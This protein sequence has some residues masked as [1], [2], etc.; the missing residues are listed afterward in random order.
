MKRSTLVVTLILG[1]L[2]FACS[3][4]G[5]TAI[6]TLTQPAA[7]G[8][9]TQIP[10][11]VQDQESANDVADQLQADSI[12]RNATLFKLL[13]KAQG[14]DSKLRS[15]TYDLSP[16][17]SMNSIM[18]VLIAGQPDPGIQIVVGPGLRVLEY[19][20]LFTDLKNF[21]KDD[22]IKIAQTGVYP[23]G[24]KVSDSYWFVPPLHK[25][26]LYTLEGY[27][28]PDTYTFNTTDKAQN[29]INRL[30]N[31]F[32]EHLCPGPDNDPESSN[33]YFHDKASCLKHAELTGDKGSPD[34]FTV[35]KQ[36]Y[37]QTDEVEAL[38]K[39]L[40][41]SSI[42]IRESSSKNSHEDAP[43][44]ADILYRR[45]L[46]SQGKLGFPAGGQVYDYHCLDADPTVW[47]AYY[48]TTAPTKG[49]WDVAGSPS[50]TAKDSPYNSYTQCTDLIPGPISAP[51]TK[52]LLAALDPNLGKITNDY[53]YLHDSCSPPNFYVAVTLSQQQ[54]N[55][56]RYLGKC[57]A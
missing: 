38:Y 12:I 47:Y 19:P 50:Q 8:V 36:K 24:S 10:F 27:L 57:P 16:G 21:K 41:L 55:Q 15:G 33:E 11:T 56:A 29:V 17:M 51:Y 53:F 45:Y 7:P 22:F 49:Y 5:M 40:T 4:G 14:L 1:L 26:A 18:Q 54:V 39:A 37:F 9:T 43:K 34:I 13:A 30:L 44:I 23:D 31:N 32:G 46:V 28:Y 25:N 52:F 3:F 20:A 6:L 35:A 48:S 2:A 42:V